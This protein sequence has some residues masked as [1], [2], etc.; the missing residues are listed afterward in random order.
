LTYT[1]KQCLLRKYIMIDTQIVTYSGFDVVVDFILCYD[2]ILRGLGSC[3]VWWQHLLGHSDYFLAGSQCGRHCGN[4][5][6][7]KWNILEEVSLEVSVLAFWKH[8]FVLKEHKNAAVSQLPSREQRWTSLHNRQIEC[9]NL[10][11]T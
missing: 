1:S 8:L 2:L 10:R 11:E 7:Q 6:G 5:S 9:I 4:M 3:R